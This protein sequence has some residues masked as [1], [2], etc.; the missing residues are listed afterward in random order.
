MF[1]HPCEGFFSYFDIYRY[2]LI[3]IYIYISAQG[4]INIH[5]FFHFLMCSS[6]AQKQHK[7]KQTI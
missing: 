6:D 1:S 5:I 4:C 2:I 3:Y 7:C